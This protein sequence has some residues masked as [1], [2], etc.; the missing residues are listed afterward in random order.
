MLPLDVANTADVARGFTPWPMELMWL[1]IFLVMGGVLILL[2][3]FLMWFY[4]TESPKYALPL[5]VFLC[6]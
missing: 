1:I 3:P 6:V 4:E 5:C 2:I